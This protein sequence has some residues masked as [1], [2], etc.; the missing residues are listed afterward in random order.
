MQEIAIP[1]AGHNDKDP[2]AI[3]NGHKES[4][5]TIL[6][7]DAVMKHLECHPN[8]VLTDENWESNTQYQNRIRNIKGKVILDIHLN[9]GPATANGSEVI[10]SKNAS[11][12]SKDFATEILDA[13]CK[14]LGT[15]SRGVLDETKTAR[16]SIGIL[17][18]SGLAALVEVCFISNAKE[19]ETLLKDNNIN[20]LGK[21]YADIIVKYD[22]LYNTK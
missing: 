6:I 2:G 5:L 19:V 7:R 21:A 12:M 4:E 13:T 11:K 3:G 16:G 8:A 10:V 9:A 15:R 17:N 14:I 22:N 1:S 18:M 20:L